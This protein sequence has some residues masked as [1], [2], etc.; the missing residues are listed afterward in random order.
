MKKAFFLF[1]SLTLFIFSHAQ[2]QL[3]IEDAILKRGTTFNPENKTGLGWIKGTHN[4]YWFEK[5]NEEWQLVIADEKGANKQYVDKNSINNAIGNFFMWVSPGS[6]KPADMKNVP[7]SIY[8]RDANSF[9]FLYENG[10]YVY[11]YKKAS[12]GRENVLPDNSAENLDINFASSNAAYTRDYNLFIKQKGFAEGALS[13]DGKYGV[14][15]GTTVHRSEFGITKGTFW[16]TSGEK[17]AF[18][19]MDESM[20]TDYD[21]YHMGELPNKSTPIKYPMAGAKSH[22]VTIGIYNLKKA[23]TIY[24]KTGEP[25]EQYLSNITWSPDE[26]FVYVAVLNRGQDAMILKKYDAKTGE[27]VENIFDEKSATYVEPEHGPYFIG[28]GDEFIWQSERDGF[29]HLYLYTSKGEFKKQL[30]SGQWTVTELLGIDEKKNLVYFTATKKSAIDNN[31]YSVNLKTGEISSLGN[32]SA[33]VHTYMFTSDYK[34]FIDVFSNAT[35][36]RIIDVYSSSNKKEATLLTAKNPMAD[37]TLGETSVFT[38]KAADGVTD[39]YCRMIKPVNFDPQKK[40]P[41]VTYVYGGPHV[42]LV[43][44]NWLQGADLWMHYMAQNGYVMFTVDNRGSGNRGQAFES[45]TFEHLGTQELL[46]QLQGV[47]WLK[48]QNFVDTARMGVF[49][50]SFGGFMST[51]LMLRHP[52][53]YK[54]A[55]AGGPVIDWRMYEIMYTERYMNTPY[56]NEKGYEEASLLNYIDN[57]KGKLMLIH[58]T[59]DDVVLWQHSLEFL[60]KCVQKRKQ[61]DYFV[62]PD[63]LHNVLGRDRVHLYEKVTEYFRLHL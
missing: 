35:T 40:Y 54:V 32:A 38:I 36:P 50:W 15:Y 33:G 52:G 37:Y 60:K 31:L 42:Q 8:W 4:L 17:L 53:A 13:T 55:V 22:H 58:G 47:K 12:C 51:G 48:S 57:L 49:G 44:N 19:R 7:L 62:Y 61:V 28:K 9:A 26:N 2:K 10:I 46:D 63:H 11:N 5:V 21:I 23:E 41:V 1:A 27:H 3:T 16:S 20:V 56:E 29:N 25:Q 43:R 6:K 14:V 39:L 45:A 59:A 24:L 18:Y 34:Y 30:T